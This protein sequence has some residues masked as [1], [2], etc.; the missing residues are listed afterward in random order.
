MKKPKVIPLNPNAPRHK[1]VILRRLEPLQENI[2]S[3]I[4]SNNN[5]KTISDDTDKTKKTDVPS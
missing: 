4:D 5:L 3:E 2:E 1:S